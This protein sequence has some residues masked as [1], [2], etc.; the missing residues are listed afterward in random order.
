MPVI[1]LL[2]EILHS[3]SFLSLEPSLWV[4]LAQGRSV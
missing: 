3:L 1:L 4:P 2:V